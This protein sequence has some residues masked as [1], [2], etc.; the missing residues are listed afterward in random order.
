MRRFVICNHPQILSSLNQ[1]NE[2]G[3]AC[4]THGRG[5]KSILGFGGKEREHLEERGVDGRMGSKWILGR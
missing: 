1:G 4:G 2:V 3:G 5:Q